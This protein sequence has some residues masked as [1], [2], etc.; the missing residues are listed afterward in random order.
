MQHYADYVRAAQKLCAVDTKPGA[1]SARLEEKLRRLLRKISQSQLT[2]YQKD[3]LL[4]QLQASRNIA[5]E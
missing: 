4:R 3:F 1:N 2:V 5:H